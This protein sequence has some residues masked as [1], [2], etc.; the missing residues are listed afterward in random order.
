MGSESHQLRAAA[1]HLQHQAGAA[2]L[3]WGGS[4]GAG[5]PWAKGCAGF[6]LCVPSTTPLGGGE[7]SSDRERRMRGSALTAGQA[8]EKAA[9]RW[10]VLLTSV[11]PGR[12]VPRAKHYY[13]LQEL[14]EEA[15]SFSAPC[16]SQPTPGSAQA[17]M[18][19]KWGT[20]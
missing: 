4:L 6:A 7:G 14:K 8:P 20:R 3:L 16:K 12:H 5:A 10:G 13:V 1:P 9:G 18:Q 2:A 19:N 11:L 15:K 17:Q